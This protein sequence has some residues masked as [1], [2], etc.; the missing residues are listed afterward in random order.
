MSEVNWLLFSIHPL[1]FVYLGFYDDAAS[2][3]DP[4]RKHGIYIRAR[5][6]LD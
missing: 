3:L 4:V 1:G 6:V 5:G 2:G